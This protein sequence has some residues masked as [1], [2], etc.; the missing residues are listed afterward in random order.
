MVDGVS[1]SWFDNCIQETNV[2]SDEIR[3]LVYWEDG[4]L[5]TSWYGSSQYG[6]LFLKGEEDEEYHPYWVLFLLLIITCTTL[7][8]GISMAPP[9]SESTEALYLYPRETLT[10]L[11]EQGQHTPMLDGY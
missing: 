8:A 1:V 3:S 11:N 4:H 10:A 9:A 2:D 7:G 6:R 5:S